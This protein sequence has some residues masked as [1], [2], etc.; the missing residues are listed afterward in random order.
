LPSGVVTKIYDFNG[1]SDGIEPRCGILRIATGQ[2]VPATSLGAWAVY[3]LHSLGIG[4]G[5]IPDLPKPGRF[6]APGV[7]LREGKFDRK[8]LV[9]NA[10]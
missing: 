7:P 9:K 8:L 4:V 1:G 6:G 3:N 10:G 2:S 5:G